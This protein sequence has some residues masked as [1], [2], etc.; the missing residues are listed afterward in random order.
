MSAV[1][2]VEMMSS[3]FEMSLRAYLIGDWRIEREIE[4]R[5]PNRP[6]SFAGR[7]S[8]TGEGEDVLLYRE[9]GTLHIGDTAIHAS[10]SHRWHFVEAHADVSF[11]DGR[12]FHQVKLDG[13]HADALHDCPPDLYRVSYHFQTQD[14]WRQ[15]WHVTGPRKDYTL[16][17]VFTRL[18]S[19]AHPVQSPPE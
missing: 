14:C 17:S 8:F 12:P 16:E 1:S 19:V 2:G 10:Q 9:D 13:H 6:Q 5:R 3:L 4:D 15:Q 11:A 7:A 18:H